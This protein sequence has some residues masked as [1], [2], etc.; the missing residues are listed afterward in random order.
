MVEVG[1]F[2]DIFSDE[3]IRIFDA[4][5]LPRGVRIGK[6]DYHIF[7]SPH[8]EPLCDEM[9]CGELTAVVRCYGFYGASVRHQ[10][11]RYCLGDRFGFLACRYAFHHQHIGAAF[12]QSQYDM[13]LSVHYQIHFPIA[14]AR[15]IGLW[16]ALV[17]A[18][19]VGDIGRFGRSLFLLSSSI[20]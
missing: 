14:K 5:L 19:S 7:F 13:L 20:A 2:W 11:P 3:F 4:A 9:V 8:I 6:I 16:W 17:D 10:Q 18:R 15:A 12:H 1:L